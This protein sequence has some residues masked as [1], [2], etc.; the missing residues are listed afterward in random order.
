MPELRI[1]WTWC[2]ESV[3]HPGSGLSRPGVADRLVQLDPVGRV[4]LSGDAVKGALRMSAEQVAQW[5]GVGQM[6]AKGQPVEPAARP[7]ALLFGG[8]AD[9]HFHAPRCPQDG[10]FDVVASTRINRTTGA[11]EDKTLRRIQVVSPGA[12]FD[13]G[14]TV[15]VADADLDAAATLALAAIASTEAVGA[16]A[17]IGWGRVRAESL[18]VELD[19]NQ[20]SNW[21]DRWLCSK[22]FEQLKTA[23]GVPYKV[24]QSFHETQAPAA[25]RLQWYRLEIDLLEPACFP[26]SPEISNHIA[27]DEVIRASAIRGAF[28]RAWQRAGVGESEILARLGGQTRWLPALPRLDDAGSSVVRAAVPAPASLLQRKR[29]PRGT[30]LYDGL[31]KF[32]PPVDDR[33]AKIPLSSAKLAWAAYDGGG[34]WHEVQPAW[35]RQARMHVARDY[36]TGSKVEGALFSREVMAPT[37]TSTRFVSWA[38]VPA[39]TWDAK[40]SETSETIRELG[41]GTRRDVGRKEKR[42]KRD[43]R[44]AGEARQRGTWPGPG[45]RPEVR[46]SRSVCD[47]IVARARRLRHA[48]FSSH[49]ARGWRGVPAGARRGMV[50]ELARGSEPRGGRGPLGGASGSR[51]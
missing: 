1:R 8:R 37:G 25:D 41:P 38:R 43:H 45:T 19:G 3:F 32:T 42:D 48:A 30:P 24:E 21:Q 11:A 13:C 36:V 2:S 4:L 28:R 20:V 12:R 39:G 33:D 7:L 14:L 22:A 27:T 10:A 29:G 23:L 5:L 46:F 44:E 40:R 49:R 34:G 47:Q 9:A 51:G 35:R 15:R 16:K 17:G 26:A 31:V 18:S 6:Y 50:A